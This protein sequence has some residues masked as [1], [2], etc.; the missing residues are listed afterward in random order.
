MSSSIKLSD[1]SRYIKDSCLQMN[2]VADADGH[3]QI[4]E[5]ADENVRELAV[6]V[7]A[8]PEASYAKLEELRLQ[9]K[10]V[11]ESIATRDLDGDKTLGA[12]RPSSPLAEV[13]AQTSD[14]SVAA[15]R[16]RLHQLRTAFTALSSWK[17][18]FE[19]ATVK[20]PAMRAFA[21]RVT[22]ARDPYHTPTVARFDHLEAELDELLRELDQVGKPELLL[23]SPLQLRVAQAAVMKKVSE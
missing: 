4:A 13:L 20:D 7:R 3:V 17:G 5:I 16:L 15:G 18:Y 23:L 12:H 21:E 8:H 1:V 14:G 9:I 11:G 2:R 6:K 10:N 19:L 22:Q